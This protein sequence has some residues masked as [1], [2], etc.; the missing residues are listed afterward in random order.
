VGVSASARSKL[1]M[2][3]FASPLSSSASPRRFS[4]SAGEAPDVFAP[5]S[6]RSAAS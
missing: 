1:A 5:S 2:A 3:L 6:W 4:T